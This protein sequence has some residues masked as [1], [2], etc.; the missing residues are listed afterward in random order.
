MTSALFVL[1]PGAEEIETISVTDILHRGGVDIT[2]GALNTEYNLDIKCAH[3][4][5]IKADALL[6]D[7]NASAFDVIIVPGGY[8]GS[9]N[10]KDSLLL[11]RILRNQRAQG[12]IIAAI[13][14]APGFVLTTHGILDASTPA[15]GYPG[16]T[17]DI[18]NFIDEPVVIDPVHR[19][20]T[21][22]GP[23]F[24]ADFAF[25]ILRALEGEEKTAQV[26]RDM[27]Y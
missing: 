19:I 18:P 5:V 7:I 20:I 3:G 23:A 24:A 16:T 12:G 2:I 1:S 13:C 21:A 26:A 10:C 14:A 15:T 4:A 11:G 9:L 27:L 6:K 22:K 8:Q 25:T 17:N